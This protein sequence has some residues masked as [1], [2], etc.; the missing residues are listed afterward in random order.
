M[1]RIEFR[2]SQKFHKTFK[3]SNNDVLRKGVFFLDGESSILWEKIKNGVN[4]L[5]I[6]RVMNFYS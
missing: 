5:I 1:K 3:V 4:K 6:T 2:V